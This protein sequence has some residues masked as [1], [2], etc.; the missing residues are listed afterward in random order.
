MGDSELISHLCSVDLCEVFSPPRVGL[1]APRFGLK[2]GEA[3]DL[4]TG[5][6]SNREDHRRMAEEYVETEKPLVVI[7]SPPC[8]VFSQLQTLVPDSERKAAQ[9]AE[10][11][12]HMEFMVKLYRRQAEC[13]RYFL[14]EHPA[15]ASSWKEPCMIQLIAD[16]EVHMA[17]SPMC[18]FGMTSSD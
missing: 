14:H 16:F 15:H 9:L 11:V 4:T 8:V 7:G 13:G 2:P 3:M 17:T 18:A 5:W 10:G 1:E 6:D 12:R